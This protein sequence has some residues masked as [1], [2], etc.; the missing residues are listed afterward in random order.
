[1][2]LLFF[3][4]DLLA[5]FLALDVVDDLD[6]VES[7]DGV[8]ALDF[9]AFFLDL[10]VVREDLDLVFFGGFLVLDLVDLRLSLGGGVG[11][12]GAFRLVL[13]RE[14]LLDVTR[15]DLVLRLVERL[16]ERF[17]VG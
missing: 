13:L 3:E 14:F 17:L 15:V 12:D 16:V 10:D 5:L 11:L 8:E 4:L 6:L 7:L 2:V 9:D 1:M